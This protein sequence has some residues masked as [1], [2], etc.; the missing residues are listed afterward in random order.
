[1][2]QKNEPFVLIIHLVWSAPSGATEIDI[3]TKPWT[4]RRPPSAEDLWL[5]IRLEFVFLERTLQGARLTKH[6]A[7]LR[8]A[9][10]GEELV[11]HATA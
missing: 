7:H 9:L 1:M 8:N 6:I 10:T 4:S 3:L 11:P 2:T 5:M